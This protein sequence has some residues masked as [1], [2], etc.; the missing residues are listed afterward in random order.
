MRSLPQCFERACDRHPEAIAV[1]C[2]NV[3]LSYRELDRAANR[4][5]HL[6]RS[7]GVSEGDAVGILVERSIDTY[8][9]LLGVLKS[10]AAYVP[11]DSSFPADRLEF[12]AQDAGLC[13]LVT[14]SGTSG[15]VGHLPCPLL[16]IDGTSVVG[17]SDERPQVYLE[18]EQL[19]YVIYTSGTTG[20]P[21]GVAVSHAS[22]VNFL[23]VVTPIYQVR[24]E[25]R[26]YQGL[27]IAFDFSVEEIWPAWLAGATLVTGP[28]DDRRVGAGLSEFLAEQ[29][30]TFL[31]CVPTLLTTIDAELPTLR[32]LLVSG[33]ACPQD[34][35]RRWSRPGRRILNAY[36]P[37]E[38]T[39]TATCG[40]LSP[41]RPV[42]IGTPL[43]SYRV[44]VLDEQLRPVPE[45][46]PGEICVGGPGVAIGYV[47]RPGLTAQRFVPNPV[48]A[49]REHAP[50][51]YRTGDL[52]RYTPDGEIEYLG[53]I[54]TQV[55]V[56]GYRIELAEIEQV[57]R[58]EPAVEN[59]VVTTL[60]RDG[61]VT[62][63]V[64]YVTLRGEQDERLRER[65]LAVLRRRLPTYMIP[66]F[67]EVL[68]E[69]PLLAADKVDRSALPAPSSPPL[70]RSAA[71][72][73]PPTGPVQCKL[74]ELWSEVLGGTDISIDE[75]F[76]C[77]LGG[78]SMSA[79]QLMSRLRK[80]P[81]LRGVAMGD[82]YAHS[83]IRALAAFIEAS[84]PA[85]E[86]EA[87]P[88][89]K[90]S[91]LRVALCGAAQLVL[92]YG[93]ILLLGMPLV[94]FLYDN[95]AILPALGWL[96]A[97]YLLLPIV[98][99]RLLMTGLKPGRYPLWGLT[100]LRFWLY[101]KVVGIAPLPLLAGSPLL[102]PYLRLMGARI[103]RDC[104]MSS[105]VGLPALVNIGAGVSIGYGARVQPYQVEAGW[106]RL[107]PIRLGTGSYLGTNCVV[108]PGAEIGAD[109]SVGDQS[110]V[111][112]DQV[113]PDGEHWSGSP[114]TR[115]PAAPPLLAAMAA[116]AQDRRWPVL[117]LL[118]Y[119]AGAVLFMLMPVLIAVPTVL[120]VALTTHHHGLLN[121][122]I[123]TLVGGPLVPFTTCVLVVLVKR[124]VMPGPR[125]G[126]HQ[127]RSGFGVRK[128]ISDGMMAT[129]LSVTHAL[130]ST[131]YLVPFLRALGARTGRWSEVATVNFV[132][133]DM[134]IIGERS[135]VADIAV[136]GPAVFHR[137]C[138]AL[139]PAEV[140]RRTFVGNGALVP[141]AA[142]LGDN[143]L[144]GVHSVAPAKP[145]EPETTWLGSPAIFLPTRQ[146]SQIFPDR[147]TFQ[148]TKW[149]IVA[150][151][152]IEYFRVTLP[153]TIA[154][155]TV[156][157]G[158]YTAVQLARSWPAW[159]VAAVSP[160]L[161]L[162]IGLASTLIVAL[163]KWVVIGR[164]RPRTE[165]LWSIWVR[166]TELITGL[167]ENLV[168][169]GF[170][171]MLTGS[172]F[173]APV[174]RLF[175]AKIGRRTWLSTT[176]LTEFDLVEVGDDT[177]VGEFTSLQTHLFED[178]V[179]KMS[180]VRIG[181]GASVGVRSVVLYDAVVGEGASLDA[182][183]L[184]MKGETLPEHT[185]WRGIPA[186]TQ[187]TTEPRRS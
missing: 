167:Y 111:A 112:A 15:A 95:S 83:T 63:L 116:S 105:V 169:P 125:P 76:F 75:D 85:T 73:V 185:R 101:G 163:L 24:A 165:A 153:G 154:S 107:A 64:G 79:A 123:L 89:L 27:S 120:V 74:A 158:Y 179:M 25:D 78:H 133:P 12:I 183:S 38:S 144:L 128:W 96:A 155:L 90:H 62:D 108:L 159:A 113:I 81:E 114:A 147:L 104:H 54:D 84:E 93:W 121:G 59:A 160:A 175:G 127:E 4:L 130:Y 45:G 161:V 13:Q 184:V 41:D 148:P 49:D 103:G 94:L 178:R 11:L 67:V 110:L 152:L 53:R 55:K 170:L 156:L 172:P 140:G 5:A 21:K 46:Q 30:I 122:M 162:G 39:V 47:N 18:P 182:M 9:A 57:L 87:E 56:R 50:R 124:A 33:E 102:A 139:S 146:P 143:S 68:A 10:G 181:D 37:T 31:C 126:I 118:G 58:E 166:R 97:S 19:C 80:E 60:E 86:V 61:V 187:T 99:G 70:G 43:P 34:L 115:Q 36:G 23:D 65:L 174:L 164:Y 29:D 150:R 91:S 98:G 6:L 106:L 131:L 136:V 82:L 171:A 132:D 142:K 28:G 69:F 176:F 168:V 149:L 138:V 71:P 100:Y 1:A 88:A 117:V 2:G 17:M 66:A 134:L 173:A 77:D 32:S 72:L 35:V 141:G 137:G 157:A 3:E 26:V 51:V 48:L 92:L 40:E 119:L 151:L 145:V 22:I 186:R 109:A 129:S 7:R 44:Y 20:K 16:E 177:A 8:I 14:T 52:G 42:T 180:R 135:F